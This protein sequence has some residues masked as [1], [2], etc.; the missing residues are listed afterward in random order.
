LTSFGPDSFGALRQLRHS[1][2]TQ[3]RW[4][5]LWN[6]VH[7]IRRLTAYTPDDALDELEEAVA[8]GWDRVAIDAKRTDFP[9]LRR[10]ARARNVLTHFYNAKF[11]HELV[12]LCDGSSGL[13]MLLSTDRPPEIR[14]FDELRFQL[15]SA[16]T[17]IELDVGR[18]EAGATTL[19]YQGSPDLALP[20]DLQL[21]AAQPTLATGDMDTYWGDTDTVLRFSAEREQS[22]ALHDVSYSIERPER[23]FFAW[24]VQTLMVT[25]RL[26]TPFLPEG[27]RQVLV[28]KL[29]AESGW[30]LQF[31][32]DG[33]G[34][35]IEYVWYGKGRDDD[36]VRLLKGS[37]S[38]RTLRMQREALTTIYVQNHRIA[39]EDKEAG[40]LFEDVFAFHQNVMVGND[41]PITLGADPD[42]GGYFDGDIQSVKI[43][44]LYEGFEDLK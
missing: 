7:F 21:T 29:R 36:V 12:D 40:V 3:P 22:L 33:E 39:I 30:A 34:N 42:G 17:L 5:E 9:F 32:N 8:Q 11:A 25:A 6:Q 2:R 14:Y 16:R 15:S 26:P 44:A 18:L 19:G 28:S 24:P 20:R 35:M 4:S 23:K 38:T 43:S 10:S 31:V 13:E 37:I 1:I 27:S 41:A